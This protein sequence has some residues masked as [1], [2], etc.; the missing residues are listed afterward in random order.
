MT[1]TLSPTERRREAQRMREQKPKPSIRKIAE[2]LGVSVGTA[3]RDVNP[4][5]AERYAEQARKY[6]RRA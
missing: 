6:K 4:E 2:A 3:H 1:A 5:A